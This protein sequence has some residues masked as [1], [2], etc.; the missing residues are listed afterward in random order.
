ML[1]FI[2]QN[3]K[4]MDFFYL[5]ELQDDL[6]EF[7]KNNMWNPEYPTLVY[8]KE[9]VTCSFLVITISLAMHLRFNQ[10]SRV[11]LRVESTMQD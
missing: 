11:L 3:F 4:V 8:K 7:V 9:W 6:A 1:V 2:Y 5:R 10:V